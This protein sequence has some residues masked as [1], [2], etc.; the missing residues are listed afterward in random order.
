LQHGEL[1]FIMSMWNMSP[2]A[3]TA[4]GREMREDDNR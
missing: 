4:Q 2:A 1:P 3:P